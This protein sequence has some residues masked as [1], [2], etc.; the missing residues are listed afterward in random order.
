MLCDWQVTAEPG[1]LRRSLK[2]V[3]AMQIDLEAAPMSP[4][5]APE[6]RSMPQ[7]RFSARLHVESACSAELYAVQISVGFVRTVTVTVDFRKSVQFRF[8]RSTSLRAKQQDGLNALI[9]DYTIFVELEIVSIVM[10]PKNLAHWGLD[11][12]TLTLAKF[13]REF[14]YAEAE[15]RDVTAQRDMLIAERDAWLKKSAYMAKE[16]RD[17]K[18]TVTSLNK[19]LDEAEGE[20]INNDVNMGS[21]DGPAEEVD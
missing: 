9:G 14:D 18:E 1:V 11:N 3:A 2:E 15:L 8:S 5:H 10:P 12:L 6:K 13:I 7:D 19:L 17:L 21:I 4:K 16:I 20:C